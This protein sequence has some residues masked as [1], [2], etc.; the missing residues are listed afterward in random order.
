MWVLQIR[1][2]SPSRFVRGSLG[3]QIPTHAM[4]IEATSKLVAIVAHSRI[5]AAVA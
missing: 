2:T 1:A 4:E 3:R 5:R